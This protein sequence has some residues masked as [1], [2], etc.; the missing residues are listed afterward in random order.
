MGW[1]SYGDTQHP[2][3]VLR[4][5]PYGRAFTAGG[6]QIIVEVALTQ[7]GNEG[8]APYCQAGMDLT[9]AWNGVPAL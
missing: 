7:P 6:N 2:N 9:A 1:S 8:G 4:Y 5:Y 3:H